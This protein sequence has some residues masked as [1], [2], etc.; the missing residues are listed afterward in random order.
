MTSAFLLVVSLLAAP[1]GQDEAAA[2][3][4]ISPLPESVMSGPTRLAVAVT[5]PAA[6][7][8]VQ[9]VAFFVDGRLVCTVERAPFGCMWDAGTI[10][11]DHH[12]RVVATLEGGDRVVGNV[13]T[14]DVGYAERVRTD[15]VLVPVVVRNGGRFV[16][17]LKLRDFDVSEDGLSQ[18]I[19]S[20]AAEDAPLDLVVAVDISGSMEAA[21]PEVRLAVKRLLSK[22]RPGDAVTLMGFNDTSFLVAERETNQQTRE[23]AVDLLSAWGG[24]ALYDATLRALDLVGK[25]WGRKGVLIFSDGDDRD[26]LVQR[27]AAMARVQASEAVLYTIGFGSGATVPRLRTSLQEYASVTGGRAYFP[28]DVKELDEVFDAV[29]TELANQYVLSYAPLNP[30]H[31]GKWRS[32]KVRVRSGKY[33]I[34]ARAGYRLDRPRI[35]DN[36]Q[37]R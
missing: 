30:Q 14:K 3:R 17:G 12:V 19:A 16:R 36:Q 11:R 6:A 9:S 25:D 13:R 20:I 29:V 1:S 10:L 4:I 27:E 2:L 15:A 33:D 18:P 26:S 24:T 8:R 31:D 32:L 5:P 34:R 37:V 28:R 7:G 22:L 21:L 23:E 35:A